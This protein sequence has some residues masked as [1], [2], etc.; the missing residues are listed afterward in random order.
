[1]ISFQPGPSEPEPRLKTYLQDAFDQRIL[2][3]G[4]RSARFSEIYAGVLR[5]FREKLL[6]PEDYALFFVSS[7]TE[8]WEIIARH[9]ERGQF[10]HVYNG[11]F[12]ERWYQRTCG[13]GK[14]TMNLPYEASEPPSLPGVKFK[15]VVCLTAN[16][17][18][19]GSRLPETYLL[20]IRFSNPNAVIAVDATSS[21]A[22]V[23]YDWQNADLWFASVQKCF[24]LPAGLG[25]LICGP[26]VL[27][28]I[29]PEAEIESYNSINHL[30]RHYRNFQTTHT[31]NVL[32][33]Y[34]LE[35]VLR[36]RDEI[37]V[38][39]ERL[40]GRADALYAFLDD[41]AVFS[42]LIE[43]RAYR[44]ETVI[45]IRVKESELQRLYDRAKAKNLALGEGYGKWKASTFRIANFPAITD[46]HYDAAL[47]FLRKVEA[48]F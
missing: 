42:P 18:S 26:R 24:G 7:A 8:C 2:S 39:Q 41:S 21:M 9:F 14:K 47:E 46:T 6:L 34:L 27:D 10:A 19:N 33:I 3:I 23:H 1:M 44:S 17:T 35:R 20:S 15:D 31:P 25:V 36:A 38:V 22:G 32:N 37:G 29:D 5:Q 4:H 13:A 30:Y 11:A 12:G 40:R 16:E 48:D 45:A 43:K 28:E